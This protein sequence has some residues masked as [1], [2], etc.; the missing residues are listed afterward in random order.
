MKSFFDPNY[1][2]AADTAAL[3]VGNANNNNPNDTKQPI[4]ISILLAEDNVLNQKVFS[5]IIIIIIHRSYQLFSIPI[6]TGYRSAIGEY[7]IFEREYCSSG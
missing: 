7:R 5:I 1:K 6:L 4:P 3:T 2:N